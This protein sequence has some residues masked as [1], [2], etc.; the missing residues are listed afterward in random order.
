MR[1]G[2]LDNA[3]PVLLSRFAWTK[4]EAIEQLRAWIEKVRASGLVCFDAFLTL[5]E[6]HL[7][8]IA[9]YFRDRYTSSFVEGIN[10]KLKVLKRRCYGIFNVNHLFQRLTLDIEGYAQFGRTAPATK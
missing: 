2:R 1:L 3:H 10:N 6:T 5:L 8:G 9:N 4:A 7:D